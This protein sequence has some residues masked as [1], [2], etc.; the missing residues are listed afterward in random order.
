MSMVNGVLVVKESLGMINS[1]SI[2]KLKSPEYFI[3]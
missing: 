3:I 1:P 2:K